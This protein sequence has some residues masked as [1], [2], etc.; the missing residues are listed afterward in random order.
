MH[1]TTLGP[2]GTFSHLA[3]IH[4]YPKDEI[5]FANTVDEVFNLLSDKKIDTAVV[6]IENSTSGLIEITLSNL[7]KHSYFVIAETVEPIHLFLAGFGRMEDGKIIYT[8]SHSYRQCYKT[9]T[10]LKPDCEI[11]YTPSN[12]ASAIKLMDNQN[13]RYLAIV[14]KLSAELYSLPVLEEH[15]EDNSNNQTRFITLSRK[16][17]IPTETENVKSSLIL[18][19]KRPKESFIELFDQ[20][21]IELIT[22]SS[23]KLKNEDMPVFYIE[24]NGYHPLLIEELKRRFQIKFLGSYLK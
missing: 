13:P 11:T 19:S 24:F 20:K 12:S 22:I 16:Q 8:H 2:E 15:I 5:V 6:P 1:V 9:L 14:P 7:I 17:M 3:T 18:F 10:K 23:L 21:G 4:Q